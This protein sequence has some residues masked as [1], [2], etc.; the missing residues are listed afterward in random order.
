[1]IGEVSIGI[2]SGG[3]GEWLD[4]NS[5]LIAHIEGFPADDLIYQWR[6]DGIRSPDSIIAIGDSDE[7]DLQVHPVPAGSRVMVVVFSDEYQGAVVSNKTFPMLGDKNPP[8]D[9]QVRIS[10][11]MDVGSQLSSQVSCPSDQCFEPIYQW[12]RYGGS[13]PAAG[14]YTP[15]G[16]ATGETYTT[17]EADRNK[18]I[19]L[20]VFSPE[21]NSPGR[22]NFIGPVGSKFRIEIPQN[23]TVGV[24]QKIWLQADT[25]PQGQEVIWT[26]SG[27]PNDHVKITDE[28]ANPAEIDAGRTNSGDFD[29][30]WTV[31]A[32]LASNPGIT[33]TGTVKVGPLEV[34]VSPDGQTVEQGG[35]KQFHATVNGTQNQGVKW[36]VAGNVM[37]TTAIDPDSG[38]LTVDT[39]QFVTTLT[40]RA[41]SKVDG[42]AFGE[43]K[44]Q[45]ALGTGVAGVAVD[46]TF[47]NIAVG[48]KL[49]VKASVFPSS[50]LQDVTWELLDGNGKPASVGSHNDGYGPNGESIS[51]VMIPA[52]GINPGENFILRATSVANPLYS[53]DSRLT[54]VYK[55]KSIKITPDKALLAPRGGMEFAVTLDP[56]M[57]APPELPVVWTV[58]DSAKARISTIDDSRVFLTL[59]G[60]TVGDIVELKAK[61]TSTDVEAIAVITVQD[62][63]DGEISIGWT[64]FEDGAGDVDGGTVSMTGHGGPKAINL[65]VDFPYEKIRWSYGGK[66]VQG[67]DLYPNGSDFIFDTTL[68]GINTGQH[69]VTAEVKMPG[70]TKWWGAVV[71]INVVY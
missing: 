47:S 23:I 16:G 55:P 24:G 15:I 58:G 17:T 33:A 25:M 46:P 37:Y 54:V 34:T 71:V 11:G 56:P 61:V 7:L 68:Y 41:T 43:A 21:Y 40:V 49:T 3:V 5:T 50:E 39:R 59:T 4:K 45:V 35:Q 20:L 30:E 1:M 6:H 12:T 51:T 13:D 31:T 8:S 29:R 52:S 60:A 27:G 53:A 67:E 48:G 18:F 44:V 66:I 63:N 36:T 57:S 42:L 32:A 22:S 62:P 26:I 9:L 69:F 10:G 19:E 70:D 38:L 65:E 28:T 14:E 64:D 2:R